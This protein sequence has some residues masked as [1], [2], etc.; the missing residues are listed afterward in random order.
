MLIVTKARILFQHDRS[1]KLKKITP[2]HLLQV[3]QVPKILGDVVESVIG[4]IYLD[5]GEDMQVVWGVIWPWFQPFYDAY[6]DT[7]PKQVM[8]PNFWC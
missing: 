8:F 2:I 4:A 1:L 7:I 3:V 6:K 5:S